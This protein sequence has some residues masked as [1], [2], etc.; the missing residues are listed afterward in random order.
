MCNIFNVQFRFIIE[1]NCGSKKLKNFTNKFSFNEN[2]IKMSVIDVIDD[3]EGN[4]GWNYFYLLKNQIYES[5]TFT[6][7]DG[8][9]NILYKIIFEDVELKDHKMKFDYNSMEW[10]IHKFF[11]NYK[12]KIVI[13][14]D[15]VEEK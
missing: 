13:P 5:L 15:E 12:N 8:K 9:S 10:A 1:S 6:S 2:S 4:I 11:L 14:I 7:Y 3:E